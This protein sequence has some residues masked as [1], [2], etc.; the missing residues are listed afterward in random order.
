MEI[1]RVSWHLPF[2]R[3]PAKALICSTLLISKSALLYST[4]L[5][6]KRRLALLHVINLEEARVKAA[7]KSGVHCEG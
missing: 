6:P 7:R 2:G 1:R 3:G 5:L 4:L